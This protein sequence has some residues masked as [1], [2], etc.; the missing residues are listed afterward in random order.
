MGPPYQRHV[1]VCTN[2][3]PDGHPKGCCATKGAEAVKDLLKAETKLRGLKG[4]VRVGSSGCLDTCE[5]GVSIVVYGAAEPPGGT[6]Y[7]R[8]TV[9]DVKEIIDEHLVGGRPVERL[10]MQPAPPAPKPAP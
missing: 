3:R 6:W 2:R 1:F 8:V 9:Q 5:H 4:A 7:E 10:R